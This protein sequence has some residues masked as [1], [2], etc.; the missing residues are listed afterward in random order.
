VVSRSYVLNSKETITEHVWSSSQM[1]IIWLNVSFLQSSQP[2]GITVQ[3]RMPYWQDSLDL[4]IYHDFEQQYWLL[5]ICHLCRLRCHRLRLFG[6]PN[7]LAA[8]ESA[9]C[10]LL[11][12]VR[13]F[14]Q[15]PHDV[16]GIPLAKASITHLHIQ[17]PYLWPFQRSRKCLEHH[18]S[19][20]VCTGQTFANLWKCESWWDNARTMPSSQGISPWL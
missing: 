20:S 2:A 10:V 19:R 4:D 18:F 16:S 17:S 12:F 7:P 3:Y 1:I 6:I 15:Q 11:R 14:W 5:A 13:H 8:I 9:S